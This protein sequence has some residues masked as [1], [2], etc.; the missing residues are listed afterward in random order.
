M[1]M[2]HLENCRHSPDG[3]CLDCVKELWDS[4]QTV[5]N[6]SIDHSGEAFLLREA[7]KSAR[8]AARSNGV[9]TRRFAA[10]CGVSPTQLSE[11]TADLP[12]C[13]PDL[14]DTSETLWF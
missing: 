4:H 11:W 8:T 12:D 6:E 3:W 13:E 5:A 2:P 14:I 1:T 7:L 10:W 9:T